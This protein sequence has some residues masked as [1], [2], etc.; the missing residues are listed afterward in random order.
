MILF[1]SQERDLNLGLNVYS[2]QYTEKGPS[3]LLYYS[4]ARIKPYMHNIS[5]CRGLI[6]GRSYPLWGTLFSVKL[7]DWTLLWQQTAE[8]NHQSHQME[9]QSFLCVVYIVTGEFLFASC[10]ELFLSF[11]PFGGRVWFNQTLF[12]KKLFPQT[13]KPAKKPA[14]TSLSLAEKW[15]KPRTSKPA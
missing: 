7:T 1:P 2:F 3:Y 5:H 13:I 4:E 15:P 8:I 12:P 9:I 11:Y 14:E 10:N 6:L